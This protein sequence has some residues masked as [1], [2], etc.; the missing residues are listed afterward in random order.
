MNIHL[1]VDFALSRATVSHAIYLVR[2][3]KNVVILALDFVEKNVLRFA[4]YVS[5]RIIHS[6]YS[7]EMKRIKRH[8]SFK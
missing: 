8:Y 5:Q 7:L 4:E 3:F 1:A 6:R 2:L